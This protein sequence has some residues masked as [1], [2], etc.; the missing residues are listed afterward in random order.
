VI[1]LKRRRTFRLARKDVVHWAR[2]GWNPILRISTTS[3]AWFTLSKNPWTSNRRMPTLRPL[4]CAVWTS[5]INV[6]PASRHE[7]WVR[8]P[9]WLVIQSFCYPPII[10]LWRPNIKPRL[11]PSM[12]LCP[13]PS[14]GYRLSKPRLCPLVLVPSCAPCSDAVTEPEPKSASPG[15]IGATYSAH[16]PSILPYFRI[17]STSRD[18]LRTPRLALA[19]VVTP[20]DPL[21]RLP[22][23]RAPSPSIFHS[24]VLHSSSKASRIDTL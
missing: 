20:S 6:R 16:L 19:C 10:R 15:Y 23:T 7:E 11:S 4:A 5:W 9:N 24:S 12:R 13:R 21:S 2:L 1:L 8:P 17:L 18:R 3:R 22:A 14:Q